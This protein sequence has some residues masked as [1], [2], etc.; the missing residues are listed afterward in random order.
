MMRKIKRLQRRRLHALPPVLRYRNLDDVSRLSPAQMLRASRAGSYI[1][2]RT[3]YGELHGINSKYMQILSRGKSNE[4]MT[5]RRTKYVS[6]RSCTIAE[7][8]E[9]KLPLGLDEHWK[10]EVGYA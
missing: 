2:F 3:C 4:F 1:L 9:Y 6:W 7:Y 5:T 10:S 8:I